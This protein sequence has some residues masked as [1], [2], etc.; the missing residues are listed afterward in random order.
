MLD[1]NKMRE[2][3][4]PYT[5]DDF[6]LTTG[7][8]FS[9]DQDYWHSK[10]KQLYLDQFPKK[11]TAS[12]QVMASDQP[13]LNHHTGEE[14]FPNYKKSSEAVRRR[15]IRTTHWCKYKGMKLSRFI[16]LDY[17][18]PFGHEDWIGKLPTPQLVVV[19]PVSARCHM[20]YVLNQECDVTDDLYEQVSAQMDVMIG[21]EKVNPLSFRSPFFITGNRL[22]HEEFRKGV[23]EADYHYVI[24]H[25]REQ[26]YALIE[27]AKEVISLSKQ[28]YNERLDY[29]FSENSSLEQVN[30][31][32]GTTVPHISDIGIATKRGKM[33]STVVPLSPDR[34]VA[35][36]K[37]E[38]RNDELRDIVRD[39]ASDIGHS[40]TYQECLSIAQE[41]NI[42]CFSDHSKGVLPPSDVRFVAKSVAKF[43]QTKFV[44][45]RK[46]THLELSE[47]A[48]F[49]A[50]C[51]WLYHDRQVGETLA[52]AAEHAGKSIRTLNRYKKAGSLQL[53]D[54][55]VVIKTK[56]TL[57][58]AAPL[59]G[60]SYRSAKAKK[61]SREII[62]VDGVW[63]FAPFCRYAD[64]VMHSNGSHS[65]QVDYH[66][67]D[68][69]S[70]DYDPDQSNGFRSLTEQPHDR[71]LSI[72]LQID[73]GQSVNVADDPAMED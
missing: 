14:F 68:T 9:S 67:T 72:E 1:F 58:D 4:S 3:H 60:M 27:L 62:Q 69:F 59:L 11:M 54:K 10:W 33:V 57:K 64:G 32:I 26:P 17:D 41:Q 34:V 37:A 5:I 24:H 65:D 53:V 29:S 8:S 6:I 36:K 35:R 63:A 13:S 23:R 42:A 52:H 47:Q 22:R 19:N 12:D 55:K 51:R 73:Q 7:E 50:E 70:C 46:K 2:D 16:V 66:S 71:E 30:E 45:R 38:G 28:D 31:D 15:Y 49:A 43:I 40:I 56:Q 48:R 20:I 61:A 21:A 44:G 25:E 39:I 18:K